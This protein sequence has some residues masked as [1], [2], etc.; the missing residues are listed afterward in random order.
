MLVNKMENEC[1]EMKED[2][3][4]ENLPEEVLEFIL[5]L[6]SPYQDLHDC[7]LV[8]KKWRRCVLSKCS[9][10]YQYNIFNIH[11]L[12]VVK[13][14]R[15]NFQKAV[16][17]FNVKWDYFEPDDGAPIITKRYSH[18]ACVHDNSMYIFGG[19]TCA[20][21]TFNDLWKLDLSTKQWSRPLA[22]GT[23]PSPKACSSLINYKSLLG[24]CYMILGTN[25]VHFQKLVYTLSTQ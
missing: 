15:R 19:C 1:L 3:S 2:L 6:I 21:T 7:M 9:L 11:V 18:T 10:Y 20:M 22:G 8:S 5:T 17:E 23:Y 12:D 24:K 25:L 4:I 16:N 14:R 13:I